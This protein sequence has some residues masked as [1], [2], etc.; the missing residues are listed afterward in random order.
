LRSLVLAMNKQQDLVEFDFYSAGP[1]YRVLALT[2]GRA[3]ADRDKVRA[4]LPGFVA[5]L[6]LGLSDWCTDYGLAEDVP[7]RFVVVSLCRFTDNFYSVRRGG[8]AVIALG[9]WRRYMAPRCGPVHRERAS[10]YAVG[11]DKDLPSGGGR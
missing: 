9:N 7:D 2:A 3:L 5:D 11:K 10:R 4:L 6:R 1:A 8:C